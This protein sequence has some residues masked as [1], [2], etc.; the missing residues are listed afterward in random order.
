MVAVERYRTSCYRDCDERKR[1]NMYYRFL[2]RK[3]EIKKNCVASSVQQFVMFLPI[4]DS[5]ISDITYR[6]RTNDKSL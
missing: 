2:M 4:C 3:R 5:R 6:M 1:A